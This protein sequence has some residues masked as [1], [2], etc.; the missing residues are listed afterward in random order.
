[1]TNYSRVLGAL[2]A[3]GVSTAGYAAAGKALFVTG[4]V[5]NERARTAAPL[6]V[7]DVLEQ[8]DTIVTGDAARA[9]LLMSDGAR[10]ALRSGTRFR[11][12]E[13]RLPSNVQR[14]GTAAAVQDSGRS[15]ATL[16][17]GGFRTRS[18]VIGRDGDPAAYEVRTPVGTLGI[19]GTDY[20]AVF[21]RN[22][23][24]DV[25]GLA[26]GQ[27]IRPGLYLQVTEGRI[28][29]NGRGL[30]FELAAP[31]VRFVPIEEAA[32]EDLDQIPEFLRRDGA[33][34][35]D[36]AGRPDKTPAANYQ[37]AGFSE[38]RAPLTQKS[39]PP[40]EPSAVPSDVQRPIDA[41]SP[42]GRAV[43]LTSGTAPSTPRRDLA[44]SLPPALGQPFADQL[45]FNA[46]GALVAFAGP[47]AGLQ[48]ADYALGTATVRDTGANT[49][50]GLAW[51]R[52][53]GGVATVT[54][55]SG[56][57][58]LDLANR[59]LHFIFGP[60]IDAVPALPI[61]G[62]ASYI[63][64]GGT[65]PTDTLG[66][67]GTLGGAFVAADFTNRS[68]TATLALAVN[69]IEWWA[70]GSASL[71]ASA[72]TFS[73]SFGTVRANA[74]VAGS[75]VFSGFFTPSLAGQSNPAGLG[76]SYQLTESTNQVGTVSGVA[77]LVLGQGQAPA[78]PL[79]RRSIAFSSPPFGGGSPYSQQ[80]TNN[81]SQFALDGNGRLIG[82]VGPTAAAASTSAPFA[83]G[84]ATVADAASDAATGL[85]WGRWTGG[86]AT[87]TTAQGPQILNLAS[88][89]LHFVSAGP[90][91][92][93]PVL[94]LSGTTTYVL[95][96]AT[97]PTGV[98]NVTG[99]LGRVFL[100]A[101]FT[102]ASVTNTLTMTIGG[103]PVYASGMAPLSGGSF[104][105]NYSTVLIDSVVPGAGTFAGFLSQ[106]AFGGAMAP[107]AGVS[108]TLLDPNNAGFRASGVLAL[109]PGANTA[110][111]APIGQRLVGYSLGDALRAGGATANTGNPAATLVSVDTAGNLL[112][113][114]ATYDVVDIGPED[115]LFAL[116]GSSL[117]NTGGDSA[118]G[119]RWGRWSGGTANISIPR[120]NDNFTEN[121][122][123]Q[124]LHWIVG[125]PF[126][127]APTLPTSGL[128]TT[129]LVGGTNPTDLAGGVGALARA[130][131]VADFTNQLAGATV[132]FTIDGRRWY[133]FGSGR[134][135]AGQ[136]EFA[137]R[138]TGL[139]QGIAPVN[140]GFNGFLVLPTYGGPA[141][142]GAGVT[143][144]LTEESG[145][146]T[147]NGALAFAEFGQGA[148]TPPPAAER[149]DVAYVSAAFLEAA[150][151]G[152]VASNSVS[153][154]SVDA[155]LDLV[156]FRANFINV[157][158]Q[159]EFGRFGIGS[160]TN[161]DT[162]Y[163][164]VSVLRW[165]RWSGGANDTAFVIGG[166]GSP[167]PFNLPNTGNG[168]HWIMSGDAATPPVLPQTGSA[169]YSFFGGTAPRDSDGAVGSV[170]AATLNA[171]FTA[172][173]LTSAL[174]L[175]FPGY[176]VTAT[177]SGAIGQ[178]ALAAHQF[179]G[180][181]SSVL[182]TP[183]QGA[184]QLGVGQL[185]GFFSGP[186]SAAQPAPTGAG[187]AYYLSIGQ[188]GLD[189]TGTAALRRQ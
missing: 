155:A 37:V 36:L 89:S 45:T 28:A 109:V 64:A 140:G 127:T 130:G 14:P 87:V 174:N 80:T 39:P 125:R 180:V 148:L 177:G 151:P 144:Y 48:S 152:A 117:Q 50:A 164:A 92:S 160:T 26:P 149:R 18:G 182:Y 119:L 70:S 57:A 27:P 30:S 145:L 41:T 143:W 61:T 131:F 15:V 168:L 141:Q 44:I 136:L 13:L 181:Y 24:D 170:I 183:T 134:L 23:C 73:G 186:T 187:L 147:V 51:G 63:L 49:P 185:S 58:N 1:M 4:P 22:D 91:G 161:G 69:S 62:T 65:S 8:G 98:G 29:F 97:P 35:L 188:L 25:P 101:D 138:L 99:Q 31:G 100:A 159:S 116:G 123:S 106:P 108:Y 11:I 43:D 113:F 175:Q 150:Q 124:S 122:A 20:T 55:S 3:I 46:A 178:G 110:P 104:N 94:P 133:G 16:L 121:L 60:P 93:T 128:L 86:N 189:I 42:F 173:S 7:G 142:R 79:P 171:N 90:F 111:P 118:T 132:E 40:E 135:T 120:L 165:G 53:T 146:G 112:G 96:G 84:T 67:T 103:L 38:R 71:A 95:L 158:G 115:A 19:R 81:T 162:G 72:N 10:I 78:Q 68:L 102:N 12:D 179:G 154:Y 32:P 83:I 82:Y 157:A 75:G 163:D 17:K 88:D 74:T 56:T 172:Q 52:W 2:I 156:S 167:I 21:C 129:R 126:G 176:T 139:V 184:S 33:G 54:S 6:Q 5:T 169:N 77:G 105:A 47:A 34:S 76:F 137:G 114:A 153:D 59:S 85:S 166:L 66:N 107:G 9:Q